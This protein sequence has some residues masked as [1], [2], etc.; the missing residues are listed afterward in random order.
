ME[1]TS[2][3]VASWVTPTPPELEGPIDT[4]KIIDYLD[5][6]NALSTINP[7][8]PE[9]RQSFIRAGT[10]QLRPR[11]VELADWVHHVRSVMQ[12]T[13]AEQEDI[14]KKIANEFMPA[15]SKRQKAEALLR[16]NNDLT[17]QEQQ[18]QQQAAYK[19]DADFKTQMM[20]DPK[21]ADFMERSGAAK[22]KSPP[23]ESAAEKQA[24]ERQDAQDVAQQYINDNPDDVV[25]SEGP[26]TGRLDLKATPRSS[27]ERV[28][29]H[30][31]NEGKMPFKE[32]KPKA[33]GQNQPTVDTTNQPAPPTE[34]TAEMAGGTV[35]VRVTKQDGTVTRR[36]VPLGK[37]QTYIKT[38]QLAG[39][40]AVVE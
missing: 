35:V 9:E 14:T 25:Y 34:P 31:M 20:N 21:Y 19:A 10:S 40:Q 17:L 3:P 30:R 33:A 36:D 5:S 38:L 16:Q 15:K 27:F 24:R 1:D 23:K 11:D 8:T 7:M 28:N 2:F 39:V 29:R 12:P 26:I 18:R 6:T 13:T 32:Y 22:A 4:I 37:V